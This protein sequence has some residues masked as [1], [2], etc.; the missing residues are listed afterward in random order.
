V[1]T[2]TITLSKVI[3]EL[4][5]FVIFP[6]LIFV[7]SITARLMV[8]I[9]YNLIQWSSPLRGSAVHKNHY[10][11]LT[12]YRVIALCYF[13]LSGAIT[14]KLM[15]GIQWNFIQWSRAV[16]WSAVQK[17][18]NS[19]LT[20]YSYC[21]LLLFCPVQNLKTSSWKSIQ[22]HTIVKRNERKCRVQ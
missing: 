12:N 6:L 7:R 20:H 9:Q 2:R 1:H 8:G 11:I 5:P 15:F 18:H 14:W 17:K 10:S 21:P 13:S 19:I 3:T 22:L 4:F 16:R